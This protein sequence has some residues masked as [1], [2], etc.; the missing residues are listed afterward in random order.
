MENLFS[1]PKPFSI[2]RNRNIRSGGTV[3]SN[4]SGFQNP[5]GLRGCKNVCLN[6]NSLDAE[7]CENEKVLALTE[8]ENGLGE[9]LTT[10]NQVGKYHTVLCGRKRPRLK[11]TN[12][13]RVRSVFDNSATKMLPIR[14][15]VDN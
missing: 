8:V 4:A 1:S 5:V 13:V 10:V 6:W 12:S 11:S 7:L 2:L 14:S 9:M 3:R 15:V